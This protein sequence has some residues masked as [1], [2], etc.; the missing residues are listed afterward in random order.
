MSGTF[1]YTPPEMDLGR[2]ADLVLAALFMS[3]QQ[4]PWLPADTNSSPWVL[5]PNVAP[6]SVTWHEGARPPTAR[7]RYIFEDIAEGVLPTHIED[8]FPIEA[9]GDYVYGVDDRLGVFRFAPD[10]SVDLLF[11]GFCITPQADITESSEQATIT[12]IGVPYRE[13]DTPIFGAIMRNADFED[14]PNEDLTTGL[15]C[16]FNPE[17]NPNCQSNGDE[18]S[19]ISDPRE[20]FEGEEINTPV[21]LGPRPPSNKVGVSDLSTWTLDRAATYILAA[22]NTEMHW[23]QWNPDELT[24]LVA[25]VPKSPGA[26]INID[27]PSTFDNKKI[28]IED[29]DVT[30]M[31]WPDALEMLCKPHGFSFRWVLE[32]DDDLIPTWSMSIFR[33][34][35]QTP[36]KQ[37]LLQPAGRGPLERMEN[38]AQEIHLSRDGHAIAN[39]INILSQPTL[40]EASFILAPAF[41]ILVEDL[42]NL[43]KFKLGDKDC[44]GDNLDKYRVFVLDEC[45]EGHWDFEGDEYLDA[46]PEIAPDLTPALSTESIR[47]D[48]TVPDGGLMVVRRRKPISPIIAVDPDTKEPYKAKLHVS[49]DYGRTSPGNWEIPFDATMLIPGIWNGGADGA[50]KGTWDE[51]MQHHWTMLD[52]RVGIRITA[53]D[54]ND[55][56]MGDRQKWSTYAPPFST[57]AGWPSRGNGVLPLVEMH[58]NADNNKSW[59]V[60]IFMM[61]CVVEADWG[62][63]AEARQDGSSPTTYTIQRSCDARHRF[64]KK[65]LSQFSFMAD[66]G[67]QGN[68]DFIAEDDTDDAKS[69]AYAMVRTH[70][71]PV[72]AGS[73]TVPR[74]TLGYLVGDKIQGITG[75]DI[76]FTANPSSVNSDEASPIYPSVSSVEW[77][78]EDSQ[79][80]T[81]HLTDRRAE[82]Q[83]QRRKKLKPHFSKA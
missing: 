41:E 23:T 21:F 34:D 64:H 48:D 61:T 32:T 5:L 1:T 35:E 30:G 17:G 8:V 70:Q 43:E 59:R 52:D 27:D 51:V 81:L 26:N 10:G 2:P 50:T 55:F 54:P 83:P 7:F 28:D 80:T 20:G 11:D 75:R 37:F 33:I 56:H 31:C 6:I 58:V 36:L 74:L 73:V 25:Y 78:F 67:D 29:V 63:L 68:T 53:Q 39:Y 79:K 24:G 38:N 76:D 77:T 49:F 44:T 65:V 14:V 15:P 60:P 22:N 42:D 18:Q 12:A 9:Q 82:Y 71:Q 46:D 19:N 40:V 72:F 69:M 47:G 4:Q 57:I 16:R 13:F 62:M 3:D 66:S 45:G